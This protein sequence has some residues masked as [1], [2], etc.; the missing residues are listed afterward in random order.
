MPS[1]AAFLA[2]FLPDPE[3]QVFADRVQV[4]RVAGDLELAEH[5]RPL[6]HGEIEREERVDLAER[7]HVAD[8]ADEANGV[9]AL[10]LAEPADPAGLD[11]R[12]VALAHRR[13]ERLGFAACR[14]PTTR[15]TR[16]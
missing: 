15:A 1:R 16:C 8:I 4:G 6:R 12:A 9:D 2:H 11:E 7:D 14:A 10:A 5:A 13:Q 3:Q